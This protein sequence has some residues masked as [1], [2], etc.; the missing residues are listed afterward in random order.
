MVQVQFTLNC[1]VLCR[2][3]LAVKA[4]CELLNS[5]AAMD[6]STDQQ[7]RDSAKVLKG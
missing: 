5:L 4:Y 1:V 7:I 2:A 6:Q 3:H